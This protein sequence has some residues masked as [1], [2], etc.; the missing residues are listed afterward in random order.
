MR[1]HC[2]CTQ[3]YLLSTLRRSIYARLIFAW[4]CFH[5]CKLGHI[6]LGRFLMVTQYALFFF[7][8]G[9]KTNSKIIVIYNKSK[10]NLSLKAKQTIEKLNYFV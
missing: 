5:E 10:Y 1:S 4:I 3:Y 8:W 2:R 9:K 7:I 6:S